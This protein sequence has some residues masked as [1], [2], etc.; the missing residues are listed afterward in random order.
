LQLPNKKHRVKIPRF[1]DVGIPRIPG[2][3]VPY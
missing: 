3:S 2:R 1:F